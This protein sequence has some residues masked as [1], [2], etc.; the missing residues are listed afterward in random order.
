MG[1]K[2]RKLGNVNNQIV[3]WQPVVVADGSTGLTTVA[4]RG[5]FINTTG[6]AITITLPSSP[7]IGDVIVINDYAGTFD[8]NAVTINRNG[9]NIN[10]AAGDGILSTESQT[11]TLTFIDAT[12]GWQTTSNAA[13]ESIGATYISATGGTVATSGNFKIHSFTGDGN[14]VVSSVGNPLGSAA[15]DYVVVAGGGAGGAGFNNSGNSAGGG[16]AG[17]YRESHSTPVSGSYTASPLATPTGITLS[18]QTYPITVG[19]GGAGQDKASTSV[20]T[21]G[22]GSNS[23]FATITAAG[24]G[25]SANRGYNPQV[26]LAGGSGGGGTGGLAGGAGN[27]PPVSPPQG[28]TGGTATGNTGGGGGGATAVGQNAPGPN[29]AGAGGAGATSGITGSNVA[30]AGGGGSGGSTNGSG[31]AGASGGTG[32]G[33]GGAD[34]DN[35]PSPATAGGANTG[36]GGGGG[37]GSDPGNDSAAG[38]KGIVIIRYK[39]QN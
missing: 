32:G 21:P 14:F 20:S 2:T 33:G 27:T 22:N 5:Y 24:G 19:G 28:N 35:S 11:A 38:G 13:P 15:A 25:A 4:G 16:G 12:R 1:I 36:G 18:A 39:F 9:S 3:E 8:T 26:G 30:R 7:N 31:G 29:T 37:G 10:G 17:G 34:E 23:V 6:G